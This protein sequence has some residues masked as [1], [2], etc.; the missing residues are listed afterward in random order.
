MIQMNS[1]ALFK[2]VRLPA[3]SVR[4][5]STRAVP[6]ASLDYRPRPPKMTFAEKLAAAWRIFF[7]PAP[8]PEADSEAVTDNPPDVKRRLK[9]LLIADRSVL[10]HFSWS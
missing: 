5:G 3:R 9:L 10:V 2:G 7:P 8:A 6:H 4:A 1:L